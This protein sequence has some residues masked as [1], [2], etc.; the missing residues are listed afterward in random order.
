MLTKLLWFLRMVIVGFLFFLG[1][2]LF[3]LLTDDTEY[4]V[5]EQLISAVAYIETY[6][7]ESGQLPTRY[8]FQQWANKNHYNWSFDYYPN[9]FK[10]HHSRYQDY[11]DYI[12]GSFTGD[13]MLYFTS[14]DQTFRYEWDLAALFRNINNTSLGENYRIEDGK[15]LAPI[16]D[17]DNP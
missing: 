17:T 5:P 1:G 3:R 2:Y 11:P 16:L 4:R 10:S 12:V 14:W 8:N 13:E 6:E 9:F 7:R 15:I